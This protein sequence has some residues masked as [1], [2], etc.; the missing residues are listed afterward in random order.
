M[1]WTFELPHASDTAVPFRRTKVR[2][3]D[4]RVTSS[5]RGSC[6]WNHDGSERLETWQRPTQLQTAKYV[7]WD[8]VSYSHNTGMDHQNLN[9]G[10]LKVVKVGWG[11]KKRATYRQICQGKAYRPYLNKSNRLAFPC[12]KTSLILCSATGMAF[13]WGFQ[14]APFEV[15]WQSHYTHT[16]PCWYPADS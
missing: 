12:M 4:D 15:S 5:K 14:I 1:K 3:T 16:D 10:Q 8:L 7:F 2:D 6:H 13:R 11:A 9:S